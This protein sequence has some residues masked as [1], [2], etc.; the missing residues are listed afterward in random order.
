M[1]STVGTSVP[2]TDSA[3]RRTLCFDT[4]TILDGASSSALM[5]GQYALNHVYVTNEGHVD[6][7]CELHMLQAHLCCRSYALLPEM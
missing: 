3:W 1:S 5:F 7:R 4:T 6:Q 2:L